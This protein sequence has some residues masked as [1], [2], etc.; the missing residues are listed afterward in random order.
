MIQHIIVGIIFI[1]CLY[2]VIRRVM[3]YLSQAKKGEAR[4]NS[5]TEDTCPLYQAFQKKN[6][7]CS[8]K[9]TPKKCDII[10]NCKKT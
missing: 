8:D 7:D 1:V 2:F 10:K 9:E 3:R 4:C 6:C 5:C